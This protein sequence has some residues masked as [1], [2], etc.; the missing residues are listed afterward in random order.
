MNEYNTS[1]RSCAYLNIRRYRIVMMAVLSFAR[2]DICF[3]L[4]NIWHAVRIMEYSVLC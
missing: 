4:V 3:G 1:D 2:Y